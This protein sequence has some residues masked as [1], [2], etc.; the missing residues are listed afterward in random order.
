[1]HQISNLTPQALQV[2][3]APLKKPQAQKKTME[4]FSKVFQMYCTLGTPIK[5]RF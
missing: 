4:Y 2:P 5:K 3:A 1:M